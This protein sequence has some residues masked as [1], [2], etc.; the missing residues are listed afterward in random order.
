MKMSD[1]QFVTVHQRVREEMQKR[2]AKTFGY[3]STEI[4]EY[5]APTQSDL[6]EIKTALKY[7]LAKL[8]SL[9]MY[10]RQT[11]FKPGQY[12]KRIEHD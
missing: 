9:D 10:V 1:D 3:K 4:K 7:I 12:E 11:R 2:T 6:D 8:T 5:V